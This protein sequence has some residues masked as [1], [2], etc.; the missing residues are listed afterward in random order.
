MKNTKNKNSVAELDIKINWLK[1]QIDADY[2][3]GEPDEKLE[4]EL[5]E[6]LGRKEILLISTK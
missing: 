3:A 2:R 1:Q 4:K 6:F 5:E